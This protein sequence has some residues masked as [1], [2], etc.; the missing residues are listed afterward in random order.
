MEEERWDDLPERVRKKRIRAEIAKRR[1]KRRGRRRRRSEREEPIGPGTFWGGFALGFF[2]GCIAWL[3]VLM[4][5]RREITRRGVWWG[6][7][8]HIVF[9]VLTALRN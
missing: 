2:G 6:F 4:M 3:L 9:G 5:A 7:A 8:A 1:R